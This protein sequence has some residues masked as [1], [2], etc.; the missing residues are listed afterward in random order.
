MPLTTGAGFGRHPG[1]AASTRVVSWCEMVMEAPCIYLY[2]LWTWDL[3]DLEDESAS[4]N[5]T[6]MLIFWR[7]IYTLTSA[8]LVRRY[9]TAGFYHCAWEGVVLAQVTACRTVCGRH[10]HSGCSWKMKYSAK[11]YFEA[12]QTAILSPH[13]QLPFML[14]QLKCLTPRASTY[15]LLR[16]AQRATFDVSVRQPQLC[17]FRPTAVLPRCFDILIAFMLTPL[18][19]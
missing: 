16:Q 2:G 12:W 18:L 10:G 7:A 14:M 1:V 3:A 6:L 13:A 8:G 17:T 11:F 4:M 15:Q 5:R 9:W 19:A